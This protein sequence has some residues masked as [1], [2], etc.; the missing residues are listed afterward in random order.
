MKIVNSHSMKNRLFAGKFFAVAIATV[1]ATQVQAIV[2]DDFE[3][4]PVAVLNVGSPPGTTTSEFVPQSFGTIVGGERDMAVT[5]EGGPDFQEASL[6]V[7]NGILF[8]SQDT[9]VNAV[10]TISWDGFLDFDPTNVDNFDDPGEGLDGE[11]FTDGGMNDRLRI[12]VLEDDLPID[13]TFTAWTAEGSNDAS[14]ATIVLPGNIGDGLVI[15]PGFFDFL[16]PGAVVDPMALGSTTF[17]T[18]LGAGADF[19]TIDAL[20]L[21]IG[22]GDFNSIDLQIQ[23]IETTTGPGPGPGGVPEPITA[24]LSLMS[25]GLLGMA[26][27]RRSA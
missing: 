16:F 14:E 21:T 9:G 20:Q 11:D 10:S 24:T 13:L 8:H 7:I 15:A 18:F 26:T 22:A 4:F 27:R 17:A 3:D 19:S 5:W 12:F 2:I 25:L 23:L 1:L 6:D